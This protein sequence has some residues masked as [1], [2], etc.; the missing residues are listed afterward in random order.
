MKTKQIILAGALVLGF[1]TALQAQTVVRLTGSTAFRGATH[2][3]IQNIMNPGYTYAYTGSTLSGASQAIFTGTANVTGNPSV[4]IKT[5]WSGAVG[6]TQTVSQSINVNYLAST[7]VTQSTGGTGSTTVGTVSE[8]PDVAMTDNYQ[9]STPFPTP[10]MVDQV[11]GIV[12]FKW[13]ANVGAPAALNNI[14]PQL[15]QTLYTVGNA[16][17]AMFTGVAADRT[18]LLTPAFQTALVI[19]N[20][21]GQAPAQV[22]AVGRD[23]DSGTRLTAFAETG[24]GVNTE[25]FQYE[26]VISGAAVASQALWHPITVNGIPFVEGN[27]GYASGGT[28]AGIFGKTTLAS[29]GGFYVTYLSTGDAATAITAGGK[30]LAYNGVTYSTTAVQEGLY[31]FWGYEHLMYRSAY[32]GTGKTVADKIANNIQT[33]TAPIKLTDMRVTRTA[34]GGLVTPNY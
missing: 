5:S 28:L 2:T 1:S 33:T 13:V 22:F 4:I 34:D 26:P 8:L 6:G 21:S 17:L 7:G 25:V 16:P 27:G 31:T 12:P 24:V 32:A 10:T 30:E 29:L 9:S 23:P 19:Y 3:A 11:V 18:T 15:A 20:G 14:T